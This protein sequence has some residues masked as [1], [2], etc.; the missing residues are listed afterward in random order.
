MIDGSVF[1]SIVR[2]FFSFLEN[3]FG[4]RQTGE[5]IKGNAFY[6]VEYRDS[7]RAISISYENVENHLEVIVF[8]LQKDGN[9]PDYDDKTKTL[10]LGHLN[11]LVMSRISDM[12][13]MSNHDQFSA[14][15]AQGEF[16]KGLLKRAEELRLCLMHVDKHSGIW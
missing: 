8:V 16:Q 13:I 4:F 15:Q 1:V 10:H 7:L 5:T 3:E 2:Q 11:T 6:D 14:Y 12:E 9:L